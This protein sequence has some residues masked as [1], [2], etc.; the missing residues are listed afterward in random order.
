MRR[1]FLEEV[2]KDLEGDKEFRPREKDCAVE[3]SGLNGL[4]GD[5]QALARRQKTDMEDEIKKLFMII[6]SSG[7]GNI[8]MRLS[9]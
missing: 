4:Y 1:A 9:T 8:R 6:D 5:C 2:K 3:K 7:S